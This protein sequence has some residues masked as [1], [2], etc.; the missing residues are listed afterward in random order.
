MTNLPAALD[1]RAYRNT[2]GLFATGV[3]VVTTQSGAETYGMTANAIASVSL[4]PML[5][6]VCIGKKARMAAMLTA[7]PTFAV[8]ILR[9]DQ[10]SLSTFFAGAWKQETPP[11]FAFLPWPEEP[12]LGQTRLQDALAAIG[13][14][15]HEVFEGGDHWIVV[16]RAVRLYQG[17][18]PRSPLLFYGG[19]YDQLDVTK[20][21]PAPTRRD[22]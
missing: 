2:I 1:P 14:I 5:L 19:R 10:E 6:L 16:G 4:D 13:C 21:H 17:E 15:K 12:A 3:A 20:E 9:A 8:N 22:M 18:P 11:P 7:A